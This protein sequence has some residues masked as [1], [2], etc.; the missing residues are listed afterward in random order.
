M[1]LKNNRP[2]NTR[3]R[4]AEMIFILWQVFDAIFLVATVID[5]LK[6]KIILSIFNWA[7]VALA[8]ISIQVSFAAILLNSIPLLVLDLILDSCNVSYIIYVRRMNGQEILGTY[9]HFP[10]FV[11]RRMYSHTFILAL[12]ILQ[13]I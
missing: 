8:A 4:V 9:V 6:S 5:I 10:P 7:T 11:F 2:S 1:V 13:W 12:L 3:Y